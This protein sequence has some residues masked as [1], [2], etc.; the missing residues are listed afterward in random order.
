MKYKVSVLVAVY[1]AEKYI[2]QCLDSLINQTLKEIQIICIDDASTDNSLYILEEYALKDNRIMVLRQTE[3]KGQAKARNLGLQVASGE[4]ITMTDSDDWLAHD[5]L[6]KAY[7]VSENFAQADSILLDVQYYYESTNTYLPYDYRVEKKPYTGKE[8][9]ILSLDWAIHGL[10]MVRNHI[11]KEYPY[12]DYSRMYSDD[13]TTRLHFLHS[14]EVH[15]SEGI[16]YYRQHSNSHTHLHNINRFD[17][18]DAGL[19]LK[20]TLEKEGLD[21]DIVSIQEN[22][23]WTNIVGLYI[24]YIRHSKEF[25]LKEQKEISEKFQRHIKQID[26]KLLDVKIKYKFGYMPFKRCF[27]LFCTQVWLYYWIRKIVYKIAG[28][29]DPS[30]S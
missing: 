29:K 19:S 12:D 15:F 11:H 25:T 14:R 5:A 3:N 23:R 4:F 1:N 8:A 17:Y 27:P 16:Y 10:Y 18:M 21:K 28:K 22:L 2:K 20:Q 9:L 26:T 24:Y 13:N 7:I 30:S 6:E